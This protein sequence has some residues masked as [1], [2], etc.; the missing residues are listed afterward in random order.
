MQI[1]PS[2][3]L[4]GR[5]WLVH[6]KARNEK[7]L[8]ADLDRRRIDYFLPLVRPG[9]RNGDHKASTEIPLFPGYLFLRGGDEQRYVT[10]TTHRA[11][12]VF[13]VFDQERLTTELA[14][15]HRAITGPE[16]ID[17]YPGIRQGRRCRIRSGHMRGVEGVVVRRRGLC[18]VFLAIGILGQSA[19]LDIDPAL[20]D[21]IE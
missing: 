4:P 19:E 7:A 3:M 17:L 18:R 9:Q 10:L 15:L 5:W 14:T 16:S 21:V 20:L 13:D 12:A 11:A 1:A 2:D 8:A 6:T